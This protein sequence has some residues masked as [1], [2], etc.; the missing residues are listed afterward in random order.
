MAAPGGT[1]DVAGPGL[2]GPVP[3]ERRVPVG[4]AGTERE[5]VGRGIL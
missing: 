4:L 3:G 5:G 2:V 1:F